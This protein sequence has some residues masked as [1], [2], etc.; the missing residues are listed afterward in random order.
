VPTRFLLVGPPCTRAQQI[1]LYLERDQ[2]DAPTHFPDWFE[3]RS[4][5]GCNK[6][7]G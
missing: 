6:T 4:E 3:T 2:H 5:Y 7:Q 1:C